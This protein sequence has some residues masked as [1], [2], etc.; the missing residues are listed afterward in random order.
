MGVPS[1]MLSHAGDNRANGIIGKM[2]GQER[3]MYDIKNL[4]APSLIT[5]I[6]ELWNNRSR[7]RNDLIPKVEFAKK[8]TMLNGELL[9]KLIKEAE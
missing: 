1:I 5:K 9:A 6:D 3:W 8:Q 7:V 4:S 2:L